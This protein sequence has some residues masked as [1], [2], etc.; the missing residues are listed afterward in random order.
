MATAEPPISREDL[1]P[2]SS[3]NV[4]TQELSARGWA[5][6][7]ARLVSAL[8]VVQSITGLWIYLAPFSVA[9]QVQVL[10]HAV[11]GLLML[12]PYGWYQTKHFLAWYRQKASVVMILGYL[13]MAMVLA[14]IVSGLVLTWQAAMGPKISEMWDL[15]HLVSGLGTTALLVAHL[16]SAVLRRRFVARQMPEFR[17]AQRQFWLRGAGWLAACGALV[18]L[19]T[20]AYPVPRREFPVPKEYGLPSYAQKFDEYR[21]NPFAPSY[22]RTESGQMVD[23]ALLTNSK[24]CGSAGCHEQIYKEWEPSAHRFSAMNPPFQAIQKKF[25]KDREP[26]ETRYCAGCHDPTSLFAGAKDIHNLSL[27]AP[28]M[29]E[30]CSCVVCHSIAKVDVRGNADY[31]LVPPQRYVWES[32]DDWR[33][34]VSDFLIRAYPQQHLA[35]YDRPIMRSAEYCGACHKQF[36]PEALNRFGLVAGQNQYD[37]WRHSHWHSDN[38]D[39]NLTCTDCH[40]RI[41]PDSTDPGRGESGAVRRTA[42]DGSHR[43]HGTVATNLFMPM[44]LKLPQWQ[45]QVRLSEEWLQGKA[46]LPEIADKWPAGPVTSLQLVAPQDARPGSDLN[47]RVLVTNRKAGHNITTGPL[48]FMRCWVHLTIHDADG[49]L[50]A[51]W[52]GIDPATR[53]ITDVPGKIHAIGNSRKEG[54]LVLEGQP[55]Y[56]D[57]TPIKKHELWQQ[58]GGKGKRTIFPGHADTQ[59]YTFRVPPGAKGPLKV[60]AD[61]NFRRYRQEFLDLMLPTLEKDTGVF[62]PKVVQATAEKQIPLLPPTGSQVSQSDP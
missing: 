54:T 12:V 4:S 60:H 1:S 49:K 10:L 22:A 46:V 6:R 25:A 45:E 27:S 34:L 18:A 59:S 44:V 62:Q 40:M 55:M 28:G 56:A 16:V 39:Q 42:Q 9:G 3:A 29:Q 17:R 15:V 32:A 20:L 58:A 13:L 35:D 37:E 57:G 11:A 5:S 41:V 36:I 21:G 26:A 38:P 24:N 2:I 43:H 30:G 7:L 51:E 48:D 33:K 14:C 61:L 8:L 52:G 19:A 23:P 47:L 31:V 53:E 50:L